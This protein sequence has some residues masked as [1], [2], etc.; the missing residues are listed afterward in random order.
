MTHPAVLP[1][2]CLL[3][4][5]VASPCGQQDTQLA[6]AHSTA[7]GQ[8]SDEYLVCFDSSGV[9]GGLLQLLVSHRVHRGPLPP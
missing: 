4:A 1:L 3:P 6:A 5:R 7:S 8:E 9:H 2:R